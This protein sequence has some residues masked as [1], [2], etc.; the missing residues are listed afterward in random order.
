VTV[1]DRSWYGRVLVERVEGFATEDEWQRAYSEIND[2]EEQL[3]EHGVLVVKFWLHI[4]PEE[5]EARF[6]D[7]QTVPYKR[8]KLT[9]EDWRNRSRWSDYTQAANAMLERTET[10]CAPWTL[11]AGNNKRFARIK[12]LKTLCKRLDAALDA[13]S[14]QKR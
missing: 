5:Q 2:F 7:R 3:S 8:W 4:T 14:K 13:H 11:V 1:F 10:A 12:V 9:E 6:R